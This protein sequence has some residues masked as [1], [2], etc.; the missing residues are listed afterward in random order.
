MWLLR[1]K[2]YKFKKYH[3]EVEGGMIIAQT[4]VVE[5]LLLHFLS[6]CWKIVRLS[7][8]YHEFNTRWHTWCTIG[9]VIERSWIHLSNIINLRPNIMDSTLSFKVIEL[10]HKRE[11]NYLIKR[12]CH[13]AVLLKGIP[14]QVLNS[15]GPLRWHNYCTND[16]VNENHESIEQCNCYKFKT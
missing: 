8:N 5:R 11:T 16:S 12:L 1:L 7:I 13:W 4:R 6:S 2:G 10:L 14:I 15:R 9:F 3:L